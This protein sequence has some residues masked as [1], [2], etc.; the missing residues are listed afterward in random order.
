[1][2]DFTILALPGAF[3]SGVGAALDILSS[4]AGFAHQSG[5]AAVRWR[6][7]STEATV[8]LSNGLKIDAALL[9]QNPVADSSIWFV[10]GLGIEGA[11]SALKRLS[12]PD[13]LQA[14]NALRAQVDGGG[15][16][17]AACSAV[18]LLQQAGVLTEKRVTTTWWL[19][20]LLQQMEPKCIVDVDQMV[21]ADANIVTAGAAFAHLDLMLHLLRTRFNPSLAEAVSRAMVIDG[22]Q[23]QAPYIVPT[24]LAAGNELA[25]RVVARFEAGLPN[26]PTIAELAVEFGMSNRT[27]SRHIKEATG[28]SVSVLLQSVRVNRARMLLQTSKMSVEQVAEQV[29]YADTTALRRLMRKVAQATP[30]QFRPLVFEA[31]SRAM[32]SGRGSAFAKPPYAGTPSTTSAATPVAPRPK[33]D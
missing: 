13:A 31:P 12:Q 8:V 28:R 7:C 19:G 24:V 32:K 20:G 21:V 10:P 14:I 29:G 22:R 4:A 5:C 16:I 6:V 1:M 2:F 27:L 18:F 25:G 11:D 15:T 26:P 17:A 33:R 3:A 30:T 9:P 23:S